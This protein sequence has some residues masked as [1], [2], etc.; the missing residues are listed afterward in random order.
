MSIKGY[1]VGTYIIKTEKKNSGLPM[2][3]I[4]K[5]CK[6]RS[7]C[8]NRK[9][10]KEMGKCSKCKKCKDSEKCD[11]FYI[12]YIRIPLRLT[13]GIIYNARHIIR[14]HPESTSNTHS[15]TVYLHTIIPETAQLFGSCAFRNISIYIISGKNIKI[16]R[17]HRTYIYHCI[18]ITIQYIFH[19]ITECSTFYIHR[20]EY[21]VTII[22]T[23]THNIPASCIGN[24]YH[25]YTA[26]I[27]RTLRP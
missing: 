15:L 6:D 5:K 26:H 19:P 21:C 16:I 9:D 8:K 23:T 13:A 1:T 2:C 17:I 18:V 22:H 27:I 20:V 3:P 12:P 11:K 24:K 14:K 25:F 10:K 4:C 7:L